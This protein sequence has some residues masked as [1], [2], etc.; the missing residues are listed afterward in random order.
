LFPER[1]LG[2]LGRKSDEFL[3]LRDHSAM[4]R[5]LLTIASR[6]AALL[7]TALPFAMPAQA[8]NLQPLDSIA[9][10]AESE[11]RNQLLSEGLGDAMVRA[12]E[13]D[14]R[15]RLAAC[16]QALDTFASSGAVRGG[17]ITVGV[18]CR[19]LVPWTLYVPVAVDARA[20]VVIIDGPLPRGTLLMEQHLR[21]EQRPVSAL[22]AQYLGDNAAVLGRELA[23]AVN[24][25]TVA[26]P[27]LLQARDLV[28]RGQS[29]SILAAGAH[30]QVRMEGVALQ[31]GQLGERIDVR[32]TS[33]G[34]TLQ[35]I[36]VDAATVQV[37]L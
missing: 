31:K 33:S 25:P 24:G 19:G 28:A 15:L 10:A 3:A 13:L 21:I 14:A 32:N 27:A 16:S 4:P 1:F 37:Q 17:R 5:P 36:I 26:T 2:P 8:Q 29:V 34:R 12:G 11:A 23:R 35:A 22:P 6:L 7:C 20:P 9:A 30:M 18:R